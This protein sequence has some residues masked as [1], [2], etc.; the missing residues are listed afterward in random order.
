MTTD[1]AIKDITE[2][3]GPRVVYCAHED[4]PDLRDVVNHLD[5]GDN[6]RIVATN[7]LRPGQAY[8]VDVTGR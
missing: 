4:A 7:A 5:D 3:S 2:G 1:D 6:V 8:I